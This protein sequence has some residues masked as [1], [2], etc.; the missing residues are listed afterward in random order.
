SSDD[1]EVDIEGDIPSNLIAIELNTSCPNIPPHP[2]AIYLD[3][4][5][6]LFIT[7]IS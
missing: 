2:P 4:P 5:L 7:I 6:A 1:P 3:L